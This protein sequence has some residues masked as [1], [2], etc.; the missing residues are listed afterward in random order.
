MS[1]LDRPVDA[2]LPAALRAGVAWLCL[3][4]L[5]SDLPEWSR[6][7][8]VWSYGRE[9]YLWA[10]WALVALAA[11]GALGLLHDHPR[12]A[13]GAL[14]LGALAGLYA[15][16]P[17]TWHNNL[18][19]LWLLVGACAFTP[20][21]RAG[22]RWLLKEDRAPLP[23]EGPLLPWLVRTQLQ[24]VYLGS[25]LV[26]LTH[27]WWSGT[28]QVLRWAATVRQPSQHHGWWNGLLA[29]LVSVP[30]VAS[31]VDVGVTAGEATLPLF[32]VSPRWR[33]AAL[34]AGALLHCAMQEWLF[35]QLFSFLMLL[36]YFAFGPVGDRAWGV[37]WDPET[38]WASALGAWGER[39]DWL[40]RARW[41]PA[42]GAAFRVTDP[43]G[44][45]L[46]GPLAVALLAPLTPATVLVYALLALGDG[47]RLA[48]ARE[49][50]EN[51]VVAAALV[52][53]AAARVRLTAA[54]SAP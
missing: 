33:G 39:L 53:W 46:D 12:R 42:A 2:R 43:A 48:A 4:G 24:V 45:A 20:G 49:P 10:P 47:G 14:V 50:L 51:A 54:W 8:A 40:G 26:K 38:R 31:L 21:P 37:R 34:A 36:G 5:W 18:Y 6:C 52:A 41:E 1:A 35:P 28:G 17:A 29:P 3:L 27:P 44:R 9:A 32:L 19:L 25:V 30:W 22:L 7:F 23:D 15:L 13:S 11:V 16:V